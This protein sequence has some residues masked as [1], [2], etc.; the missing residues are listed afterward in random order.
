MIEPLSGNRLPD[1]NPEAEDDD[2]FTGMGIVIHGDVIDYR[3]NAREQRVAL[4][5]R[6]IGR[7]Y[8]SGATGERTPDPRPRFR[9]GLSLV[10]R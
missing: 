4:P 2:L 9:M 8:L 7:G 5:G 1:G 3:H 6:M 10:T